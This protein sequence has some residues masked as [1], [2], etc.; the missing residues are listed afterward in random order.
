MKQEILDFVQK[1]LDQEYQVTLAHLED[2]SEFRNRIVIMDAFFDVEYPRYNIMRLVKSDGSNFDSIREQIK[3][4]APRKV[5]LIRK[6]R[7]SEHGDMYCCYVSSDRQKG[8]NYFYAYFIKYIKGD[9][10]I[11]ARY[12]IDSEYGQWDWN[13]GVKIKTLGKFLEIRRFL[14]PSDPHEL[15]DFRSEEGILKFNNNVRETR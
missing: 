9:L 7:N 11:I 5:F 4:N 13:G 2:D 1:F 12:I 6:Y 15:D 10:K 3:R 8:R 14:E